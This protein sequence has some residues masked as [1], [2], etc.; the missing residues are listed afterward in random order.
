MPP[1]KHGAYLI[2]LLHDAGTM[3]TSDGIARSLTWMDLQAWNQLSGTQLTPWE[4]ET[5]RAAS[6][7]YARTYNAASDPNCPQP[8]APAM[9]EAKRA[10]VSS[11]L[12]NGLRN[13]AKG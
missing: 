8:M 5:I 12:K 3:S 13:R 10:A 11:G 9:D 2:E 6:A 1:L 7:A 4:C